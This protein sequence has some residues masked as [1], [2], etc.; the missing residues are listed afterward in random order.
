MGLGSAIFTLLFALLLPT[1]VEASNC[2][3]N[4]DAKFCTRVFGKKVCEPSSYFACIQLK[5]AA[6][7]ADSV[8]KAPGGPLTIV[9]QAIMPSLLFGPSAG[10]TIVLVMN[11]VMSDGSKSSLPPVTLPVPTETEETGVTHTS[12]PA[13]C[14]VS[15]NT[16]DKFLM[17]LFTDKPEGWDNWKSG[18][19]W[20]GKNAN[21]TIT[22]G[23][24][25]SSPVAEVSAVILTKTEL[26]DSYVPGYPYSFTASR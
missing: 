23:F 20:N 19:R 10:I 11:R 24:D 18:D 16:D 15:F 17:V 3:L 12:S 26:A 2:S 21:P 13:Q 6:C 7:L 25:Q 1:R 22:C 4:C 8:R 14:I 5:E 9:R